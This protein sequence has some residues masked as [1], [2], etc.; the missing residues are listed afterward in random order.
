MTKSAAIKDI[1]QLL[2][3][4]LLAKLFG[5]VALM[6]FARALPKSEMAV[7]PAWL[8]I[9]G[10]PSLFLSFGVFQ[11]LI[12]KLPSLIRE[13]YACARSLVVTSSVVTLAG[14]ILVCLISVP[15]SGEIAR[16]FFRDA[17]RAWIIQASAIGCVAATC[18]K[19]TE[20]VMWGEARF[21]ATS[22]MQIIES[23]VRPCLTVALY[24]AYGLKGIVAGLV[25]AQ[26]VMAAISFWYVRAM[27][28]GALPPVYPLRALV[29][30]SFPFYIDN[31]LWYLKGDG[32]TLLVAFLGPLALAE[33]YI[34]KNLYSNVMMAWIS[35]DKVTLERLARFAQLPDVFRARIVELY[36]RISAAA[37]PFML[38]VIAVAPYGVIVLAG[39]RYA[40]S[41]WPAVALLVVALVQFV[42]IP[43]NRAVFVGL[44]GVYRLSTSAVEAVVVL[45]AAVS[46]VPLYGIMGIAF[47]RILGPA[48]GFAFGYRA[49]R[50]KIGLRLRFLPM[51]RAGVLATP[52]TALLLAIRFPV[53]GSTAAFGVAT[54]ASVVWMAL[55]ATLSYAFNRPAF[56]AAAAFLLR[57]YRA[58]ISRQAS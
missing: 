24:F 56:D 6:V 16:F 3:G 25:M 22:L 33:Y 41:I 58:V 43:V 1:S 30:E 32:D 18:S 46:L 53:H 13:D 39:A 34:A 12:R 7:F 37:V 57:R 17:G 10:L 55:F 38:L 20:Y 42:N 5:V 35:L 47:A 23:V 50:R 40:H 45:I 21:G 28:L 49:L 44:P 8:T 2:S 15:F 11:T 4:G 54:A 51:L 48:A 36:N 26:I 14:T 31:Y 19:I 52:G 29:R 9:M 27:F